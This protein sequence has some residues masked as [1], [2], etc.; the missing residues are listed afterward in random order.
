MPVPTASARKIWA[1]RRS[2]I[3]IGRTSAERPK[4]SPRIS[5]FISSDTI[6]FSAFHS[7]FLIAF[8][9]TG[10]SFEKCLAK[11]LNK[12]TQKVIFFLIAWHKELDLWFD[13][14]TD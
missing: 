8:H 9:K 14:K 1:T 5:L 4:H 11:K 3:F 2:H 12:L 10:I 7:Q 6:F 13:T